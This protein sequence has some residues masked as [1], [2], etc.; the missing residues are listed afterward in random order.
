MQR[1]CLCS[2]PFGD[3]LEGLKESQRAMV[4]GGWEELKT[5]QDIP[6]QRLGTKLGLL[7]RGSW[8]S[9]SSAVQ[10]FSLSPPAFAEHLCWAAH[11]SVVEERIYS[12]L[13]ALEWIPS[14]REH[15]TTLPCTVSSGSQET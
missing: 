11:N 10:L 1:V 9:V 3:W 14:S 5:S 12:T 2:G 7:R 6:P 8:G 4:G 15:G 13:E